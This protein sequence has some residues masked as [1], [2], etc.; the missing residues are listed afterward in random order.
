MEVLRRI[1]DVARSTPERRALICNDETLNYAQFW[2]LI[3]R[4]RD[5]LGARIAGPG[6]VLVQAENPRSAWIA[7]LALRSL[8]LDTAACRDPQHVA[9]FSVEEL[10]AVVSLGDGETSGFEP[11]AGALWLRLPDP[12][13]AGMEASAELPPLPEI[14][15][16]GGHILLTSAT[17]GAA[18][19]VRRPGSSGDGPSAEML[20]QRAQ[21]NSGGGVGGDAVVNV[22]DFGLWTAIG[23]SRPLTAWL[24]GSTVVLCPDR[25]PARVFQTPGITHTMAT[26]LHVARLLAQPEDAYAPQPQM[27]LDIN[28]GAL[29]PSH[30]R[31]I[32][33]RLTP[34][35][36]I[37]LG[38]TEA[39]LWARTVVTSDED[40]R[41]YTL[42]PGRTVEVVDD[43]GAPLPFGELGRL[44][45]RPRESDARG[46][47]RDS[48]ASAAHFQGD[49]FYPG[50]L[51]ILDGKGR[52]ELLGRETDVVNIAGSKYPTAPWERALQEQLGCDGV[53]VL[54]GRWSDDTERLHVFIES[55]RAIQREVLE[56]ALRSTLFGFADVRAHKVDALPRTSTGKIRRIEIARQ[57]QAG[58]YG[59]PG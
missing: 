18:K 24:E 32:R 13:L 23:Y 59:G 55:R 33:R 47:Q 25:N 35:L 58:A 21:L 48:A 56:S 52:V 12:E 51:A 40:L 44:R 16:V 4:S 53:C 57:L 10:A 27:L 39:G 26:P 29:T 7:T 17:T 50:D 19:R 1:H 43:A 22:W 5:A 9:A 8:G 28:G 30:A 14:P 41:W 3:V 11:P 34:K 54:S 15:K 46:Y 20:A 36:V 6:V 42:I 49:W 38:S 2:R 37:T 45:V 31:E